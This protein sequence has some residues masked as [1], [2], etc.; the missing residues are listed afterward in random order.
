MPH[1]WRAAPETA[2]PL[3]DPAPSGEA[4]ASSNWPQKPWSDLA[5]QAAAGGMPAHLTLLDADGYPLPIRVRSCRRCPEGFRVQVPHGAPW[6]QGKATLSFVGK[7]IFVGDAVTEGGGETLLRVDRALPVLPM[8]DDREG[9]KPEVL[10][11]LDRARNPVVVSL[12]LD[13]R[14]AEIQGEV[15]QTNSNLRIRTQPRGQSLGVGR[16]DVLRDRVRAVPVAARVV[17]ERTQQRRNV[18]WRRL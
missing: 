18:R 8:M 6:A 9:L 12:L 17:P 14:S 7:E 16:F 4:S 1:E 15:S 10:A 11:K 2:F 5:D 13:K 3:S